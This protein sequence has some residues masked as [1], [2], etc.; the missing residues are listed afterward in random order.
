MDKS[1]VPRFEREQGERGAGEN[2]A[3]GG[4]GREQGAALQTGAA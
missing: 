2:K 3:S 4:F 1:K